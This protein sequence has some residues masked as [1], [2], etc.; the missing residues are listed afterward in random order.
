ML[1]LIK[2]Y[3]TKNEW[4]FT[5][6]SSDKSVLLFGI[7]GL[8][9][10]F[11]CIADVVED[12]KKFIFLS[13]CGANTPVDKRKEMLELINLINYDLFLGNFEIDLEDGEIRFRTSTFYEYIEPTIDFLN[14]LIMSNIIT[15]D[16]SL[17][18]IMGFMFGNLSP[19]EAIELINKGEGEREK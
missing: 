1:D 5:Q 7:N 3:F 11:Q 8:N 9:G 10:N 19:L 4:Q 14:Q 12:E 18:G 6:A 2:Q 13:V 17:P 15:M 16:N